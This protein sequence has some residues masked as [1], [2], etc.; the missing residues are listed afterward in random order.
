M[1]SIAFAAVFFFF[2]CACVTFAAVKRTSERRHAERAGRSWRRAGPRAGRGER[3]P[4]GAAASARRGG[5]GN[6]T[7][8]KRGQHAA[9]PERP[10]GTHSQAQGSR[11][12]HSGN[13]V[14]VFCDLFVFVFEQQR[15]WKPLNSKTFHYF[16]FFCFLP[17]FSTLR[18]NHLLH[19]TQHI[20]IAR[21][22]RNAPTP[23]MI[24][25]Q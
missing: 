18:K 12:D 1:S 6:D 19:A 16:L 13:S 14:C 4:S 2:V 25:A 7:A 10:D 21:M 23:M 17:F 3:E 5:P 15:K 11:H 9:W 24:H 20:T 8:Q 22:M